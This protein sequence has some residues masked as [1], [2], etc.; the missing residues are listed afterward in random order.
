M[1]TVGG[2]KGLE[3]SLL[4]SGPQT[5]GTMRSRSPQLSLSLLGQGRKSRVGSGESPGHRADVVKS[6]SRRKTGKSGVGTA[7]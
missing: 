2:K 5:G 3:P 4:F 6:E 7:L 1:R